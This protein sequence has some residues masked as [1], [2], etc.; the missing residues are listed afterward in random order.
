[1]IIQFPLVTMAE[2]IDVLGDESCRDEEH[3]VLAIPYC[4]FTMVIEAAEQTIDY[5]LL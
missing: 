5:D 2:L 4:N 1:M 3:S